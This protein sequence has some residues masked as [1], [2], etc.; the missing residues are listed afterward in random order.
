M[1]GLKIDA[2]AKRILEG[3]PS[4]EE[5]IKQRTQIKR[6]DLVGTTYQESIQYPS[7]NIRGMQS[8]LG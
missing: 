3:V 8:G 1:K 2:A 4:E 6:N 5:S 7:L